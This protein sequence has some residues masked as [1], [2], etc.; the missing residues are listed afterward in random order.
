MKEMTQP[1]ND[2]TLSASESTEFLIQF[3]RESRNSNSF[4]ACQKLA[5]S[6]IDKCVPIKLKD[7]FCGDCFRGF[8]RKRPVCI[9]NLR[10]QFL[11]L[12]EIDYVGI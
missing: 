10:T 2:L 11:H 9:Y 8:R 12:L 5:I 6:Q 1:L 4:G 3:K 7:C